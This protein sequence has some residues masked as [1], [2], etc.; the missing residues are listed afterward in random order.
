MTDFIAALMAD[1]VI[2]SW[3]NLAFYCSIFTIAFVHVF[4]N[5]MY[6]GFLDHLLEINFKTY[7]LRC[8]PKEGSAVR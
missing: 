8:V 6:D 4:L 2:Y 5:L 1:I 7:Q 3:I